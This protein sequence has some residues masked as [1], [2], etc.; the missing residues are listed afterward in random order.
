MESMN[1]HLILVVSLIFLILPI[2]SIP[3]IK[4]QSNSN[5]VINRDGSVTGTNS[6]QQ[7]GNTYTLTGNISGNVLV[8]K[9][10]IVINGAGYLL[11]GRGNGGIDLTN[12][13]GTPSANNVTIKNLF[14]TN[15][16]IR[17][18][19]DSNTI[20]NNYITSNNYP[21]IQLYG[22][23]Y[24]NISYCTLNSTGS[25]NGAILIALGEEKN[26][27]TQNNIY[28]GIY[29]Y[30]TLEIV[31][32]NYWDDYLTKYPNATEIDHSGVG[33]TPYVFYAHINNDTFPCQDTHPLM[34]PVAIPLTASS[35]QTNVPEFPSWLLIAP[36]MAA[37][38][39]IAILVRYRKLR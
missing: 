20:Y 13:W 36:L 10:N 29:P 4:A 6:I 37:I 16:S 18:S 33:N 34:K 38:L 7:V 39:S 35:S 1:K 11:D 22:S 12:Q 26:S 14:I 9:S 23:S 5:I 8:E 24:S 32:G 19:G 31:N 25:F 15:G 28:G 17:M 3:L 21:S 27:I 30:S 2:V